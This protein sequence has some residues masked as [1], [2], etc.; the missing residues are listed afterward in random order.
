MC[1]RAV[2]VKQKR[3]YVIKGDQIMNIRLVATALSKN[4]SLKDMVLIKVRGCNRNENCVYFN[5]IDYLVYEVNTIESKNNE[6]EFISDLIKL[7]QAHFT[8]QEARKIFN[9]IKKNHLKIYAGNMKSVREYAKTKNEEII[10]LV[11]RQKP[12]CS[13]KEFRDLAFDL[14]VE[15]NYSKTELE[16]AIK[17]FQINC[18]G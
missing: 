16:S 15:N 3:E 2:N 8:T 14:A 4:N 9:F 10:L 1:N 11:L 18:A 17:Y 13:F 7:F 12:Y 5:K 6:E